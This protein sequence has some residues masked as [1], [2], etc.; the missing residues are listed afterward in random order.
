MQDVFE[1]YKKCNL[2]PRECD[3]DRY[4]SV[5]FCGENATVSIDSYLLHHGEEPCI[6][7][8]RGSGTIFFTGCSLRCPFCQNRQISQLAL[9]K[10]KSYYSFEEFLDVIRELIEKGAENI[11]FVTPD[12]FM[13]HILKASEFLANERKMTPFVYNCSGFQSLEHLERI[14]DNIEIF[15]FDY[16]FADTFASKYCINNIDYPSVAEKA[17]DFLIK[18]KGHLVLDDNGKA[19]KGVIIRHLVMPDFIDNSIKVIN[20]LY[21]DYG[22][23]TYLSLMSQYSPFYL[24]KNR[25]P[26]I[27]RKLRRE[28]YYNI[29]E[30]VHNFGFRNGYIQEFIDEKDGYIP[31]FETEYIFDAEKGDTSQ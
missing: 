19:V 1:L 22:V 5:G 17:L 3:I 18:K 12:H 14:V 29:V 6:S 10:G 28:E 31:D 15:L 7:F 23:D 16:K 27:A 30:L 21:F 2:C 24:E 9:D 8:K 26:R 20:K 11:N 13:P 25:Y 4:K